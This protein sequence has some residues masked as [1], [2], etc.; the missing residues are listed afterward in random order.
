[1]PA[2]IAAAAR[3]LLAMGK[4]LGLLQQSP[5]AYLKRGSKVGGAASRRA[6]MR[7][8]GGAAAPTDARSRNSSPSAARRGRPRIFASPTVYASG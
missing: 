6:Q 4:V 3:S 1:M 2:R 7:A 5:E 8:A